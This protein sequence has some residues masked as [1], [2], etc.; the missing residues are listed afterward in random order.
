MAI[1]VSGTQVIGNSRE[2]TNIASIDTTTKNSIAAAGIGGASSINELSDGYVSASNPTVTTNPALGSLWLN[3][4]SGSVYV[5]VDATTN[6]NIWALANA[7]ASEW[8]PVQYPVATGG[9]ITTHGNFKRHAFTSSSNFVVTRGGLFNFLIVSGGG[10]GGAYGGIKA[11]GGGGA[12]GRK[13][14]ETVTLNSGTHVVTVG[15]G[16]ALSLTPPQSAP[17]SSIGSSYSSTGGGMGGDASRGGFA[18]SAG[19]AGGSGGGASYNTNVGGS[20]I[21]GEGND[22]GATVDDVGAGGGGAGAAGANGGSGS[23]SSGANGGNGLAASGSN[24]FPTTTYAGGGGGG[25]RSNA[26]LYGVGGTGGGGFGGQPGQPT[27]P[28]AGTANTG[29]GGGGAGVTTIAGVGGSGIVFIT[30]QFQ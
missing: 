20:G 15:A 25:V 10:A 22:G 28:Q 1:Q 14:L 21:V 3:S 29:G 9:T 19:S 11:G 5:C 13:L 30:Y 24:G 7:A 2:L 26:V 27:G 8:I 23:G 6:A 4:T 17:S 16:M 18:A 12:G